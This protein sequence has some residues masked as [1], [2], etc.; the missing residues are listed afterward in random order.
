MG[1]SW[2]APRLKLLS[3]PPFSLQQQRKGG[4]APHRGNACAARR[5]ADAGEIGKTQNASRMPAKKQKHYRNRG[6]SRNSKRPSTND[7]HD[8]ALSHYRGAMNIPP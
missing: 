8:T 3:F 4:A 2:L 6:Y 1:L 5:I 7:A